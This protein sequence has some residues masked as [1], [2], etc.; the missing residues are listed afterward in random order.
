MII[1]CVHSNLIIYFIKYLNIIGVGWAPKLVWPNPIQPNKRST[2]EHF[3]GVETTRNYPKITP[4]NFSLEKKDWENFGRRVLWKKKV[5][6]F[7]LW[8]RVILDF[9]VV[10]FRAWGKEL[11][12]E[13]IVCLVLFY[14]FYFIF[15][16]ILFFSSLDLGYSKN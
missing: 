8:N 10:P 3:M 14:L 5:K 15:I 13:I 6:Y 16:F 2:V 9:S 1:I 11:N 12:G 4:I 7:V